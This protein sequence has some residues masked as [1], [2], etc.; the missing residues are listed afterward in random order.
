[1]ECHHSC[2]QNWSPKCEAAVNAQINMELHAH[3]V[4][5]TMAAYYDRDDVSLS[6][7]KDFFAASAAEERAHA[8][9]LIDYQNER[10]GRVTFSDIKACSKSCWESPIEAFEDALNLE[11]TVNKSLLELH[12]LADKEGD[13]QFCDYLE[14]T[15]LNEQVEGERELAGYL[16]NLKM[17]GPG[18]GYWQF[19]HEL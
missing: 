4:Y 1:M 14:G 11:K 15:F 12:E 7:F 19:Q 2:R 17:V 5:T 6:G 3:Y 16:A 9:L 10:G 8:Q 13:P 18:L